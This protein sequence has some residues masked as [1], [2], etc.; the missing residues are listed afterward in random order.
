MGTSSS[1][2]SSLIITT[3]AA[4]TK[5]RIKSQKVT[6][7]C[8][9]TKH[10]KQ[11]AQNIMRVEI[12]QSNNHSIYIHAGSNLVVHLKSLIVQ[13]LMDRQHSKF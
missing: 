9:V 2:S 8:D 7:T 4:E 13:S 11:T 5:K 6:S 10:G 12:K 1:S 3:G